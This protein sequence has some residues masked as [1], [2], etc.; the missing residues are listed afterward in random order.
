MCRRKIGGG[1]RFEVWHWEERH[2]CYGEKRR[3][4]RAEENLRF[5]VQKRRKI[6][7]KHNSPQAMYWANLRA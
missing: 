1:I 5:N 7:Y 6:V 3:V 2:V 4:T